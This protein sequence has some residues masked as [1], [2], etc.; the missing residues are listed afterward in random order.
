MDDDVALQRMV[1]ETLIQSL[2][3]QRV[4]VVTLVGA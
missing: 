2:Q 3:A 1:V 4:A